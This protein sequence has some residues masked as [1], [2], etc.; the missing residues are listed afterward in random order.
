MD[1]LFSHAV[2]ILN[3]SNNFAWEEKQTII[4]F[5]QDKIK[6]A[7][8]I[9]YIFQ[10]CT[11]GKGQNWDTQPD[12]TDCITLLSLQVKHQYLVTQKHSQGCSKVRKIDIIRD[13]YIK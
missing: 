7:Q 13:F 9:K 2:A 5:L 11:A 6:Q 1:K 12:L 10:V 3:V 4:P 8:E